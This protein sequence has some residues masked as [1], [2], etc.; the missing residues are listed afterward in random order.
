MQNFKLN[1]QD[2]LSNQDWTFPTFTAYG[3]G[4][5]KEIGKFCKNFKITNP[6]IVIDSG[7]TKLPFINDLQNLLSDAKIKS[8][9]YSNISPN[10][11]D[12]EIDVAD[13]FI[14]L[15]VFF[16]ILFEFVGNSKK[17]S[18]DEKY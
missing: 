17:E 3:P 13:I 1:E 18:E 9:I 5:F 10:P 8:K 6:L 7:S 11:R 16:M 14:S 2:L 15:G 4:R 12:D